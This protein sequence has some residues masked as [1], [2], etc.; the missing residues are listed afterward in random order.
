LQ[1]QLHLHAWAPPSLP[2]GRKSIRWMGWP[3]S[4]PTQKH[5]R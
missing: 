4:P 2:P 1:L 3:T 5:V